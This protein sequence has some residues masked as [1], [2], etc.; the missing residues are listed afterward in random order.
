MAQDP[1]QHQR[2][3]L[4]EVQQLRGTA[5]DRRRVVNIGLEV[6]GGNPGGSW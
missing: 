1:H 2:G 4:G 5:Q 6:A 3:G